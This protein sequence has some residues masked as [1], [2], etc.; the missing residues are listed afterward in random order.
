MENKK[1]CMVGC[2]EAGKDIIEYL[3]DN[4]ITIE[5]F[6]I[7]NLEQAIE[8]EISGYYDFSIIA[9]NY[10]IP[11]Y[12]PKSFNLKDEEDYNFF[13]KHKFDLIIQGGWQRLIPKTI[14][15]TF[16]IGAIGVHGSAN[17]L[18]YGRGRSP[19]NWSLIEGRKRFIMHL[20][21]MKAGADDGDVFD[22]EQFDINEFDTIKTLYYKNS[23]VTKRMLLRSIP[24][25]LIG[26][27][28]VWTQNGKPKYYPK[29]TKEDGEILWTEWNVDTIFNF[30]RALT[31]PYPGAY[32]YINNKKLVIWE[33]QIFD[34]SIKYKDSLYGEIVEV[35]SEKEFL[36]N[37]LDGLLLVKVFDFDGLITIKEGFVFDN[38]IKN[39]H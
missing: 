1:I 39:N 13:K 3:L 2:H 28:N 4:N 26:N 11:V 14:L 8:H 20:F 5:Y 32:S 38:S 23:I 30:I 10:N 33:S 6:V 25:L 16:S 18:P 21:L 35:F 7:L 17:F 34:R 36:I 37:C 29:R 12:Y 22:Y 31:Q 27:I 15:D 24:K 9:Q 19:L